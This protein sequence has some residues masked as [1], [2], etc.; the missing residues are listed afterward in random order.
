MTDHAA[1]NATLSATL[2]AGLARFRREGVSGLSSHA[3]GLFS[4]C[5]LSRERLRSVRLPRPLL[6]FVLSGAKEVWRGDA[7]ERFGCGTLFVLPAEV[8]LDIVNDP[9]EGRGLYQSLIL[10]IEADAIP[11]LGSRD[12]AA[13][14]AW[15]TSAV[16]LT[17]ELVEAM[18]HAARTIGEGPA[19]ATVRMARLAEL[20]AL[21]Y[22]EPAARPL[23]DMSVSERVARLV[24]GELDRDWTAAT[25]ARRIALSESTL[26]RRLAAEG[27]SYSAILRRERMEA[28]RRLMAQGAASGAAAL[29]VGYASRAHFARAFR[30]AFGGNPARGAERSA[31]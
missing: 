26:R 4:Y 9:D 16:P 19:G 3:P 22:D 31:P 10:E 2:L 30:A 13:Q 8:D 15:E 17:A 18:L 11:D 29:A 14:A 20:L 24:R 21:L 25:V 23:F 5:A 6:G 12:P 27:R 1:S 7:A 28:A